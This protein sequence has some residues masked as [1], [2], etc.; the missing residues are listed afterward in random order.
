MAASSGGAGAVS[1]L[2]VEDDDDLGRALARMLGW[3]G[4]SVREAPNP[5][6][7]IAIK[8]ADLAA[9]DVLVS[10]VQMP[11]LSGP[12]LAATAVR[13]RPRG[14]ARRAPAAA[15]QVGLG[16]GPAVRRRC[17]EPPRRA[18]GHARR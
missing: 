13:A 8:H 12:A 5:A 17:G 18:G 11:Q 3:L 14:G 9:I 16:S 2:V 7:A 6:S 4:Y 1:V 10:D 15:S